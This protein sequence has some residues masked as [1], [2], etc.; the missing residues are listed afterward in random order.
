MGAA[1]HATA[2]SD[3]SVHPRYAGRGIGADLLRRLEG[4][5][6]ALVARAPEGARLAIATEINATNERARRLLA[7]HGYAVVR[8]SWHMLVELGGEPEP[9]RWPGGIVVRTA[10][11]GRDERA[12]WEAEEEAFLDHYDHHAWPFEEWFK[13]MGTAERHD[14]SLWFLATEG[15]QIAGV[16]LCRA[17]VPDYPG[18]GW[19]GTLGVRRA[20]RRRGVGEALLRRVRRVRPARGAPRRPGR[21]RLQPDRRHAPVRARRHARGAPARPLREGSRAAGT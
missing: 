17:G 3:V 10:V 4:R 5:A 20:W 9:P 13:L 12:V 6:G 15:D 19:V 8:H 1:T 11:A 16:A 18:A 14:V 7:E 21:G 2:Y